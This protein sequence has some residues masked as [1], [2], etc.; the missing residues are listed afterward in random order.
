MRQEQQKLKEELRQLQLNQQLNIDILKLE[1]SQQISN[2]KMSLEQE[3]RQLEIK[4]QNKMEIQR[5][6]LEKRR[7]NDLQEIDVKDQQHTAVLKTNHEQALI[8]LKNYFNDIVLNNMTLIT[9][10]KVYRHGI[11][12][13]N[14]INSNYN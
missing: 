7:R 12:F 4:F 9:S 3:S 6:E 13:L 14:V 8:D 10:M 1:H 2:L 11:I 5:N